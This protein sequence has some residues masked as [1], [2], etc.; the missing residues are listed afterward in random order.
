M[1]YAYTYTYNPELV[2]NPVTSL[3]TLAL[4]VLVIIAWWKIFVKAGLEGWKSLIPLYNAYL[5][6]KI[7]W[8]GKVFWHILILTAACTLVGA[9]LL[10]MGDFYTILGALVLLGMLIA[11]IVYQAKYCNRLAKSF[12][13]PTSFAVGLFFLNMIFTYIL[14]FEQNEYQGPIE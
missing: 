12:G 6:I 5:Q 8:S 4:N 13:K 10:V 11:L 7:A 14:A 1:D 2:Y 3:V 9:L